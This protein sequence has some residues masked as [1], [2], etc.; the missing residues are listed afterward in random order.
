MM[1]VIQGGFEEGMWL[2]GSSVYSG[3]EIEIYDYNIEYGLF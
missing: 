2:H 1:K 3:E